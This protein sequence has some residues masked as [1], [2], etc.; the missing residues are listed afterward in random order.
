MQPSKVL[1][2]MGLPTMQV[3]SSLR[4]TLSRYTTEEEIDIAASTIISLAKA[5][6]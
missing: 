5:L 6:Q 4:F 3:K 1:T 2:N